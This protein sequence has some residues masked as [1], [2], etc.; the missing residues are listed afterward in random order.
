MKI[1]E[2]RII[3]STS[4]V[5]YCAFWLGNLRVAFT[6]AKRPWYVRHLRIGWGYSTVEASDED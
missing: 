5:T 3:R 1:V 2:R 4:G 6:W